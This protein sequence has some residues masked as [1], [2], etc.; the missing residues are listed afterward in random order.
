MGYSVSWTRHNASKIAWSN[1]A[2][3]IRNVIDLDRTSLEV[4]E[5]GFA[6]VDKSDGNI[7]TITCD[8]ATFCNTYGDPFTE[9][10]MR[11]LIVMTEFG[12]I[13]EPTH[14]SPDMT[15]YITALNY[16]HSKHPL[17]S[18]KKQLAYFQSIYLI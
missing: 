11:A 14:S 12:I 9:D 3:V 18:Y 15:E 8:D 1:S 4:Y 17:I 5:W 13:T 6:F 10:I 16:V 7:T 2:Q